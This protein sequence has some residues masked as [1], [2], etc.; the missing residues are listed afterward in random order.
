MAEKK[1]FGLT[2][3]KGEEVGIYTGTVP[4]AAAL[5]AANDNKTVIIL[6][7]KGT[8]RLHYFK[9]SR[10]MVPCPASAPKWIKESAAKHQGKIWKANVE[11]LGTGKLEYNELTRNQKELFRLPKPKPAK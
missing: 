1:T 2:N 10:V 5:K 11:K 6:R 3:E 9:G 8:K 7:E 4:R